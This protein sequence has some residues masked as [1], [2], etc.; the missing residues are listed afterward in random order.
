VFSSLSTLT[1]ALVNIFIFLP[2]YFS[3]DVLFRTLFEPWKRIVPNEKRVG[4]SFSDFFNDLA[5]DWV[6]RGIGFVVR[7]ATLITYL[8]VQ[9]L[10]V[11]VALLIV[12]VYVICILPIQTLGKSLGKSEEVRLNEEKQAFIGSHTHDP[13]HV[14]AVEA[15]FDTWHTQTTHISRWWELDN[16]FNVIPIGRDWA[17]GYTPVLDKFIIDL[18]GSAAKYEDRPMTIGREGELKQIEDVLCKTNGANIL[19]V[20]E[21][22]VGKT[23]II[24]SLA[25]RIH[26][27]R[28]NPL[29]AFK[30]LVEINLEKILAT[31]RDPKVRE[32]ILEELFTEAD[33]AGNIIFVV[34]NFDKYMS[35]GESRVDLSTPLEKFLRSNRIHVIGIT[36]PFAYQKFLYTKQVLK[37]HFTTLDVKEITPEVTLQILLEHT[38]RFETRYK[39]ALLYETLLASVQKSAFFITDVPFPEKALLVIDECC[40]RMKN[41]AVAKNQ[42][43]IVTPD[44]VDQVL[45]DRTHVPTTLTDA[46]KEKLL[47]IYD[48]LNAFVVGQQHTMGELSAALQRSFLMI[49]KRKKPLASFLFLGPTGVGK[50]ETAKVLA[51]EFFQSESTMIRFDMSEFQRV[52]DIPRLIGNTETG[53]PGLL[54][55]AI[56]ERPYG[57]LLLDEI[58]K[59]H[60]DLLNIFLTLLDEG[61]VTD[62]LGKHVDCKSLVVIGTSNAGALEFYN[63]ASSTDQNTQNAVPQ[64]TNLQPHGDIMS[65]LIEKRYFSPEFLNRFDG[66]IAFMPLS[67]E[68]AFTIGRAMVTQIASNIQN[69]HNVTLTVTD[70]TLRSIIKNHF[71]TAYGA[72]DLQRAI[73]E[74]VENVIAQKI[75]SGDAGKGDSIEI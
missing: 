60:H 18:S 12:L 46:F 71:N 30:R 74:Q 33:R 17:Q 72:R 25:Y 20:G 47:T 62:S 40:N 2:Y 64:Q 26:I 50:T 57:V 58:E 27:G 68:T 35:S 29:L 75:L 1:Q 69:L 28:G 4:F 31:D 43:R 56:R 54:V 21:E 61:Y 23:T 59:A 7:V 52:E 55:S 15:W 9:V 16:L 13:A 38:H 37:N 36:T 44:M 8:V 63:L 10:Y 66:V 70:E 51:R 11:P 65:F 3:V 19:M 34:H 39:V 49:G 24:E 14:P 32:T 6:S 53:D 67:D 45:S 22:G 42:V 5:F 48:K 41:V 73:Q